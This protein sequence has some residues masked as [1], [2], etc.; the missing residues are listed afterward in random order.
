[1]DEDVQHAL[2]VDGLQSMEMVLLENQVE[3]LS[4]DL[5]SFKKDFQHFINKHFKPMQDSFRPCTCIHITGEAPVPKGLSA[6]SGVGRCVTPGPRVQLFRPAESIVDSSPSS[7]SESEL[8]SD[9]ESDHLPPLE[10]RSPSTEEEWGSAEGEEDETVPG[11][12]SYGKESGEESC[13]SSVTDVD[14]RG[15][16]TGPWTVLGGTGIGEDGL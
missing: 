6:A 10:E 9:T 8:E 3:A 7:S 15:T 2:R 12:S 11:G 16:P 5:S 13:G 1:L 14:V 4:A